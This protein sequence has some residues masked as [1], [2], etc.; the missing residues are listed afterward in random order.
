[1]IKTIVICDLLFI[2]FLI[3]RYWKSSLKQT[4]NKL[5][6]TILFVIH[7]LILVSAWR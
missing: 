7:L 2:T 4:N 3:F 1:M 5:L 6:A